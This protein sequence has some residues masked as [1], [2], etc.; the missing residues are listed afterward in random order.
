MD[1]RKDSRKQTTE[2]EIAR[3]GIE[4]EA[5]SRYKRINI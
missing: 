4:V 2:E 3:S 5:E 1:E